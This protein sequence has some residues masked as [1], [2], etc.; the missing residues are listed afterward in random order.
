MKTLNNFRQYFPVLILV[1][2]MTVSTVD[3]NAQN[4]GKEGKK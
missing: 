1:T 4:R 2:A 3:V